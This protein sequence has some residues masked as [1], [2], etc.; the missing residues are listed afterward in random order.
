MNLLGELKS[1][2]SQ[3][4]NALNILNHNVLANRKD[5]GIPV[6][7]CGSGTRFSVERRERDSNILHPPSNQEIQKFGY[8]TEAACRFSRDFLNA[9][10]L[11][12]FV[13]FI[14]FVQIV[15]FI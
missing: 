3:T 7:L 1:V 15:L 8:Y 14:I 2:Y 13:L 6:E 9:A 11:V 4:N 10:L 5:N 12:H